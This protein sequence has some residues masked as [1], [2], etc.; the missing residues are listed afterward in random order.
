MTPSDTMAAP[1]PQAQ[2]DVA[3]I[4]TL[5]DTKG[6]FQG[7]SDLAGAVRALGTVKN[8]TRYLDTVD[9]REEA[10]LLKSAAAKIRKSV[11]AAFKKPKDALNTLKGWILDREKECL[12]MPLRIEAET[13]RLMVEWDERQREIARRLEEDN[14]RERE[15]IAEEERL[16]E[17]A[18]V[19]QTL[20]NEGAPAAEAE[21]AAMD[22]VAQP[23]DVGHVH[24][25]PEIAKAKGEA[26]RDYWHFEIED[27]TKVPREFCEP[28]SKKLQAYVNGFKGEA[29]VPGVKFWKETKIS[30][31]G[32]RES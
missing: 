6:F 2:P 26:S 18:A 1:P 19:R 16:R 22:V 11:E 9:Q 31:R 12:D 27:E 5:P 30:H 14:R 3:A 13:N 4:T 23:I 29:K 28:S 8:G 25:E 7:S 32:P 21:K 10:S 24:Y 15:R 20:I 17:A